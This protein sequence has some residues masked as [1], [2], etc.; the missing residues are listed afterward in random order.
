MKLKGSIKTGNEYYESLIS[1][2]RSTNNKKVFKLLH[3][4]LN[5]LNVKK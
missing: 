3:I 5:L 4:N 1:I 2:G